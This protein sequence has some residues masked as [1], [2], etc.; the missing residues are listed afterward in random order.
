MDTLAD[1][2]LFLLRGRVMAA[3]TLTQIRDMLD[4]HPLQIRLTT[5]RPRDLGARLL[6]ADCVHA[7][8][9]EGADGLLVQALRP[10]KFFALLADL[11]SEEA[12]EIQRLQVSDASTHAVFNYLLHRGEGP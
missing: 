8:T 2:I 10:K 3:G 5:D 1:R 6:Q 9:V 4:E 12:F 7:V 11:A